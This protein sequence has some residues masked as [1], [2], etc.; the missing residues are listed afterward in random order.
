MSGDGEEGSA[1]EDG[2]E[3]KLPIV[4]T[5][6]VPMQSTQLPVYYLPPGTAMPAGGMV[7]GM[8]PGTVTYA[9]MQADPYAQSVSPQ[10]WTIPQQGVVPSPS[11]Q[12]W[13]TYTPHPVELST[14]ARTAPGP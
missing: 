8:V 9:T 2:S 4:Q 5:M 6:E 13:T 10:S 12:S 1:A 14:T 7:P 3:S 11:P